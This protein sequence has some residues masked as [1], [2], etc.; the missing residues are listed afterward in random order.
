[1][2][3]YFDFFQDDAEGAEFA[4]AREIV[5]KY[6]NCYIDHYRVIF[7]KIR[8]QLDEI[9]G[10]RE[11]TKGGQAIDAEDS[12]GA[13]E[14]QKRQAK[15]AT[16][17][18]TPLIHEIK[19]DQK[20]GEISVDSVNI[21][22]VT[23]KYY[24][25][26]AE[27]L[28]SRSPFVKD[29]A[30]QFSY[31]KPYQVLEQATE[32]G[33][34]TKIALPKD[35]QGKNVVMEINSDELQVFKTYYSSQLKVHVNEQFGE[36]K[37]HLRSTMKPLSKIYVKVFCK[38]ASGNELFYRDGFTDIRGKFEYANSSGRSTGSVKKFAILVSHDEYGQTIKEVDPPKAK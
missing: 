26:D 13:D 19:V 11:Q 12:E 18:N 16:Q 7:K 38:D 33:K 29:Q 4:T 32:A 23:V 28:F 31:V 34:L 17:K 10:A 22:K 25:I 14:E 9:D 3:A 2:K 5:K 27:I 15:L 36:L 35:L 30:M 20:N 8:E 24:L 21:D 1:M 37:V 6:E